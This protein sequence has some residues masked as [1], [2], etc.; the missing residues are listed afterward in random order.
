MEENQLDND[1]WISNKVMF[2]Y[3]RFAAFSSSGS[4]YD[5]MNDPKAF[6]CKF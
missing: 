2:M 4:G 6:K 1:N 3:I 5:E